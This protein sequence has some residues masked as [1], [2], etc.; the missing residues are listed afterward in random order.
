MGTPQAA[1]A[2]PV[3]KEGEQTAGLGGSLSCP[4]L[5][6]R[7]G[8]AAREPGPASPRPSP[9]WP[10]RCRPWRWR[11]DALPS[12]CAFSRLFNSGRPLSCFSEPKPVCVQPGGKDS[13]GTGTS[14]RG[15]SLLQPGTCLNPTSNSMWA[16]DG[17]RLAT[18]LG[19][20]SPQPPPGVPSHA[21]HTS[22]QPNHTTWPQRGL[23]KSQWAPDAITPHILQ[24]ARKAGPHLS[25]RYLQ[26]NEAQ[27]NGMTGPGPAAGEGS[28]GGPGHWAPLGT[29]Q[30]CAHLTTGGDH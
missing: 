24:R 6:V 14:K 12:S 21:A 7:Q 9:A 22:D 20:L 10:P 23:A 3:S 28:R 30:V 5:P 18:A 29:A 4:S 15:D 27:G 2:V 17:L 8:E 19:P 25:P 1:A 16:P 26:G 11:E 13:Q